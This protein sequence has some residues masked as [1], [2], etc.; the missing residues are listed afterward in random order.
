MTKKLN[1]RGFAW[2]NPSFSHATIR[3]SGM[4]TTALRPLVPSWVS[5]YSLQVGLTQGTLHGA[6]HGPKCE[7][8]AAMQH[9]GQL[10]LQYPVGVFVFSIIV[11]L[12]GS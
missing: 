1:W 9:G 12:I 3:V 8:P 2:C 6:S 4:R 5:H 7:H 11:T 10:R